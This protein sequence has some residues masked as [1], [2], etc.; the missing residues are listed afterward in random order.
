MSEWSEEMHQCSITTQISFGMQCMGSPIFPS[1]LLNFQEIWK[2]LLFHLMNPSINQMHRG[3]FSIQ[4]RL[5][6]H[7][8]HNPCTQACLRCIRGIHGKLPRPHLT[9]THF[10]QGN[11]DMKNVIQPK[12][13]NLMDFHPKLLNFLPICLRLIPLILTRSRS[14]SSALEILEKKGKVFLGGLKE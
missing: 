11:R 5:D 1:Y 3:K 2:R 7:S 6:K 10:P 14:Q 8:A 13:R 12:S 9:N 4:S